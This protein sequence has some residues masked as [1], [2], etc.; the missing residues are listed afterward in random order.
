MRLKENVLLIA[1]ADGA[2]VDGLMDCNG[3]RRGRGLGQ[4]Y[5][6]RLPPVSVNKVENLELHADAQE[7]LWKIDRKERPKWEAKITRLNQSK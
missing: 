1:D 5:Y 3:H 7:A 2:I 6:E 4:S